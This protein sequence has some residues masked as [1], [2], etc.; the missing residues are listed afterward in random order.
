MSSNKS[1]C[2]QKRWLSSASLI[3]PLHSNHSKEN[4]EISNQEERHRFLLQLSTIPDDVVVRFLRRCLW[5]S[6]VLEDGDMA[7]L[8]YTATRS[9]WE[10]AMV[11]HQQERKQRRLRQPA[12]APL[13][14]ASKSAGES[15]KLSD[16]E[17]VGLLQQN[18]NPSEPFCSDDYKNPFDDIYDVSSIDVVDDNTN[19]NASSRFSRLHRHSRTHQIRNPTTTSNFVPA[20]SQKTEKT[21][22]FNVI[23]IQRRSETLVDGNDTD[24]KELDKRSTFV[25]IWNDATVTT[26]LHEAA[27][28]GDAALINFMLMSCA[29]ADVDVRNGVGRTVLH[30]VAGGLTAAEITAMKGNNARWREKQTEDDGVAKI[31]VRAPQYPDGLAEMEQNRK[32]PL[33]Q[34]T[35]SVMTNAARTIVGGWARS[36][37]YNKGTYNGSERGTS[38][39]SIKRLFEHRARIDSLIPSGTDRTKVAMAILGWTKSPIMTNSDEVL[40]EIAPSFDPSISSGV[41]KN[42][43]DTV[44]NRTALH[45]A[46]ELGRTDICEAILESFYGTM[47]TIVDSSG[48]TPCEL[49]ALQGHLSLASYLEARALLYVDPYGTDED[50][51]ANIT[52]NLTPW[53]SGLHGQL[54]EP[55]CCF[56]TLTLAEVE[57]RRE[58]VVMQAIGQ[59]RLILLNRQEQETAKSVVLNNT[60][61]SVNNDNPD[62][63]GDEATGSQIDEDVFFDAPGF[64]REALSEKKQAA[65]VDDQDWDTFLSGMHL[66]HV[67]QFMTYHCWNVSKGIEDFEVDPFAAFFA[68]QVPVP[69]KPSGYHSVENSQTRHTCSICCDEF[70]ATSEKWMQLVGCTHAFCLDCLSEYLTECSRSNTGM[71]ISCPHHN[72]KSLLSPTELQNW[73]PKQV[74]EKLRCADIDSFVVS[75]HDFTFCPRAGC[76][77]NGAVNVIPSKHSKLSDVGFLKLIGAVCTNVHNEESE[78]KGLH[79]IISQEEV[80]TLTYEGVYEPRCYDVMKLVQPKSAHRFCFLC[81]E[82]GIHWPITCDRLKEWKSTITDQIGSEHDDANERNGANNFNDVAQKLWVKANTRPCP[83]VSCLLSE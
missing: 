25:N 77:Q 1:T 43:V 72:C 23:T 35:K 16:R 66:G 21:S 53:S 34:R 30:C 13:T 40:C 47:L 61:S 29:M 9:D 64:E 14:N 48:Q 37:R 52:K 5:Q 45:Y 28:L 44:L 62:F 58:Q 69:Q 71:V 10:L 80:S 27:R 57:Q 8:I 78:L 18:M 20:D 67:K 26:P 73:A 4:D 82:E 51:L 74:H 83:K 12:V 19:E 68:A 2:N 38:N 70:D 75:A 60:I 55:F 63:I 17:A 50:L 79:K 32:F 36:L 15:E 41:S 49:A 65:G 33:A 76:G 11:A 54:V 39:C 56:E 22:P 31:G 24:F 3:L 6:F 7:I 81:R 59:M 42:A 46:A